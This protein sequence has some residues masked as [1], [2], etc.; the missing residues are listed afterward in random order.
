[1]RVINKIND[2]VTKLLK[3][4]METRENYTTMFIQKVC[5]ITEK[6]LNIAKF[7]PQYL[8]KYALYKKGIEKYKRV[9]K[10]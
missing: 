1:V 5:H 9:V 10:F 6:Y 7:L 4:V 2:K 8:L 3:I